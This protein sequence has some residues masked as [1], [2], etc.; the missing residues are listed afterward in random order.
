M[1]VSFDI[2]PYSR[3]EPT[4]EVLDYVPLF[5]LDLSKWSKPGGKEELVNDLR[6]AIEDV[7]F[8]FV[9]GH[10]IEDHEVLR[11]LSIGTPAFESASHSSIS[12]LGFVGD[13]FFNLPI[14]VKR[15][16]PCDFA[17]GKYVWSRSLLRLP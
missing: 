1:S 16:H 7:G 13:A 17:N 10:G 4:K 11:Q 14:D 5:A 8:L 2:P 3:P 9:V 12:N 6:F 15:E